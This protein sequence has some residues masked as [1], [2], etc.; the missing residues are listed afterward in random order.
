MGIANTVL[1][2]RLICRT[3]PYDDDPVWEGGIVDRVQ[4]LRM[5]R[6]GLLSHL[7]GLGTDESHAELQKLASDDPPIKDMSWCLLASSTNRRTN[8]WKRPTPESLLELA[9]KAEGRIINTEEQLLELVVSSLSNIDMRL[10]DEIRLLWNIPGKGVKSFKPHP[11]EENDLSDYVKERLD[12]RIRKRGVVLNR[13]VKVRRGDATDILIEAISIGPK[14]EVKTISIT[15]EVKCSWNDELLSAMQ[16]QLHDRYLN[17]YKRN[18]GIYL[19][20]WFQSSKWTES[21]NKKLK[22]K[23]RLQNEP[24]LQKQ[25]QALSTASKTISYV[26]L[27][28]ELP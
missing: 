12:D 15:V 9:S 5:F 19:V 27:D 23:P 10:R 21:E 8:A 24:I 1:F 6:D 28:C 17:S 22:N 4:S 26:G 14:D 20:G 11:K 7:I 2:Y 18:F 25:A 13:E 3:V 16:T